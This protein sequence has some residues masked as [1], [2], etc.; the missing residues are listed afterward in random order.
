M[1]IATA[2]A[3]APSTAAVHPSLSLCIYLP[4][5]QTPITISENKCLPFIR[6]DIQPNAARRLPDRLFATPAPPACTAA[7]PDLP[8]PPPPTARSWRQPCTGCPISPGSDRRRCAAQPE[9][10]IV[11]SFRQLPPRRAPAQG[12]AIPVASPPT[13]QPLD[14]AASGPRVERAASRHGTAIACLSAIFSP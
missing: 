5:P 8:P 11:V 9:A 6:S 7:S 12:A 2:V 13:A 3:A 14:R 10:E 4:I 1:P